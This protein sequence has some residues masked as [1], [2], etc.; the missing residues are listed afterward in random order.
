VGSV[1]HF[2]K[3]S[4]SSS[5]KSSKF[6]GLLFSGIIQSPVAASKPLVPFRIH[7]QSMSRNIKLETSNNKTGTS[8]GLSP[9]YRPRIANV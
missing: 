4:I 8:W 7:F 2:R 5:V 3:V 1:S 9:S 6:S